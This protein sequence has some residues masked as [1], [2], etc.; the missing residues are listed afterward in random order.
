MNRSI[1]AALSAIGVALA[2]SL[3]GQPAGAQPAGASKAAA[4]PAAKKSVP[5]A[6]NGKPDLSG[7]RIITS[8]LPLLEGPEAF[9]AARAAD[10]A[11]GRAP[12]APPE[13]PP[14]KPD[15]E[16]KRQQFLARRGIDDPMGRCLLTGVPRIEYRPLPLEIIQL[17]DRVVILYEIHHAFRIIPTDGRGHPADL[18]PSYL[19]DSIAHW[20]GD[21]LVVEVTGFNENTWLAGVGTIHSEQ[22]R[23]TERFT[24]DTFDTIRYQVTMEDPVVFTKPWHMEET[25]RLRPNERLREYECIEDNEDIARFEKQL[26]E[27]P[28]YREKR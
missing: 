21:T 25:F 10:Q 6:A 19:G 22:L 18:E 7:I 23:V 3:A 15:A 11:A 9:A 26:R 24:R 13:P 4:A 27:D 2:L 12:P 5:R 28:L 17:P 1:H 14:Y 8:A 16:A 20:D